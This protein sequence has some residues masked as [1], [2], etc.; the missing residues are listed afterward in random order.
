MRWEDEQFIKVY[1]RDT[2]DWLAL[3]YD[4]R[5]LMLQLLRKVDRAGIL[6]LGRHGRRGVA[7]LLGA[8]DL[9]EPRL[10]G[11]L[12]ELEDDGCVRVEGSTLVIPNFTAAQEARA[13]DRARKQAQRERDR[14]LAMDPGS[15]T[16]KDAM[17]AAARAA[18]HAVTPEVTRGHAA[19]HEVT[20]R[21]DETRVDETT[22]LPPSRAERP[23][24]DLQVQ[25]PKPPA[26]K[27]EPERPPPDPRH[28]PLVKALCDADPGYTFL[29]GADAKGVS[30]CLALADAKPHT[31]GEAA[32]GEVLRRFRACRV[33]GVFPTCRHLNDLA[34]NWNA[35]EKPPPVRGSAH[36]PRAPV[37]GNGWDAENFDGP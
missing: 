20:T 7:V 27:R 29:G 19:S 32:P 18:T 3:S 34:E 14:T 5:S 33:P 21:I 26:K 12:A 4:A 36:N 13:T 24:L 31:A 6:P 1:T 2:V 22:D 11:A 35:F 8:A 17:A 10:S 37:T 9:W 25:Q 30:R 15:V 23:T 28:A 16:G